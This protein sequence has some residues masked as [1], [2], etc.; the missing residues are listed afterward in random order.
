[1]MQN[2]ADTASPRSVRTVHRALS[3]AAPVTRV[4][5]AM[6]LRKP[7]RSATWLA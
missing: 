3:N 2:R 5:K 1:M 4:L 7:N 6:S